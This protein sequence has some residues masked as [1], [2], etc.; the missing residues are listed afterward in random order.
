MPK[1]ST[2]IIGLALFLAIFVI[3]FG[4]TLLVIHQVESAST[5]R[6]LMISPEYRVYE[7]YVDATMI[8]PDTTSDA[9]DM[10]AVRKIAARIHAKGKDARITLCKTTSQVFGV[11]ANDCL[12]IIYFAR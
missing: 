9:D 10:I 8:V 1:N 4:G 6:D 12:V 5:Q 2:V 7:N 11:E 3:L